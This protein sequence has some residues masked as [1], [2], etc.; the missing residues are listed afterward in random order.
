MHRV[1]IVLPTYNG[2]DNLRRSINSV[3]CQSFTEWELIIVD[4]C[5]TDNTRDIVEDYV[6]LDSRIKAIHNKKNERLPMSLNIGFELASGEYLTW[7]SDDNVFHS[8]ALYKMVKY[9]D[10][11][12][13]VD[14]VYAD[15]NIIDENGRFLVESIRTLPDEL[16]FVNP[17]GGCFLYRKTIA[18]QVG[19]YDTEMFLAEDYEYWIRIYLAGIIEHI[20]DTL[21]D[22]AKTTKSLTATRNREIYIQTFKAKEKHR[23]ELLERCYGR[24]EK[25]R[26][27]N[28]MIKLVPNSSQKWKLRQKYYREDKGFIIGDIQYR[29]KS[30]YKNRMKN[31]D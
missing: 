7:T 8:D 25:N 1:S 30:F 10:D 12:A 20:E 11:H 13:Y 21:Y 4:D 23:H 18:E 29:I 26:F 5:S 24:A 22:Y 19:E 2:G 15:M 16:R 17:I 9:L 3:L 27:Y 28:E 14:M 6:V 31:I